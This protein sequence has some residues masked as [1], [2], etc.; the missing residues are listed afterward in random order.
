MNPIKQFGFTSILGWSASR[1]DTFKACRRQYFYN[2]YAKYDKENPKHRIDVLKRMTSIPLETGNI[3]HDVIE[4]LLHRLVKT[5]GPI[6]MDHFQDYTRRMTE[7]YCSKKVFTEVYYRELSHIDIDEIFRK[8]QICLN[9][10]LA[11][12]RFDW[13]VK[14][15]IPEKENWIIEPGGYGETRIDG[16]KAYCKVDF[17]FPLEDNVFILDWKTGK[18][19]ETKHRKQLLGYASWASYHLSKTPS[20]IV[21]I[22]AYLQ[23][24]YLEKKLTFNEFDIQDFT[25]QVRKE[26]DEMYAYCRNIP[27][28]IPKDKAEFVKTSNPNICA[29]CNF[30]ELCDE[31]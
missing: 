29:Y 7:D 30:R 16:M 24:A 13:V 17:L 2:Y 31:G 28:N 6:H 12:E 22:I 19:N 23:P 18:P 3:V 25:I 26:T 10:F 21:P 4:V 20:R 9:N 11:G 14:K 1:Y 15:A 8:V 27:E 5:V